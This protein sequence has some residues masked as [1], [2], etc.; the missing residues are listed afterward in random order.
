MWME[1]FTW[2]LPCRTLGPEGNCQAQWV[3]QNNN[4]LLSK[5]HTREGG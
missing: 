4:A 5:L 1:V 2:A 3:P